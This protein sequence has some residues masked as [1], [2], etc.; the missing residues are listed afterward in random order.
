MFHESHAGHFE[1]SSEGRVFHLQSL[2][3]PGAR[4]DLLWMVEM[5]M[6]MF[7]QHGQEHKHIMF[8]KLFCRSS[9]TS[10]NHHLKHHL[11]PFCSFRHSCYHSAVHPG[12]CSNPLTDLQVT[13][14]T[15]VQWT[16]HLAHLL[17]SLHGLSPTSGRVSLGETYKAWFGQPYFA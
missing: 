4:L 9:T 2:A 11:N 7:L 14:L 15:T 8:Y 17:R 16:F 5:W 1:I 6:W 12:H 10:L 3:Y 13:A